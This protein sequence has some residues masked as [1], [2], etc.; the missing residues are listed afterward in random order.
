MQYNDLSI[1][2][3]L[4]IYSN[5][6]TQLNELEIVGADAD[7]NSDDTINIDDLVNRIN[8][9]VD[10][11]IVNFLDIDVVSLYG[12]TNI[13]HIDPLSKIPNL[14]FLSVY[15]NTVDL[16]CIHTLINLRL[17]ES[18]NVVSDVNISFLMRAKHNS[19]I[20]CII[21]GRIMD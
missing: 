8:L 14:T 20:H 3:F 10:E 7:I 5:M 15:R 13:T 16:S 6:R 11:H 2:N 12:Y 19:G 17:F 9:F 4:S 18:A 21:G 1:A